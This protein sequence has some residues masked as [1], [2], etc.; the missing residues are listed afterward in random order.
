MIL[1]Q[2]DTVLNASVQQNSGKRNG[3]DVLEPRQHS[4]IE[5]EQKRNPSAKGGV[6]GWTEPAGAVSSLNG[7]LIDCTDNCCM[8][9]DRRGI[10][11]A[12]SQ[13]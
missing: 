5:E 11:A 13:V 6:G 4:V 2:Q 3:N 9:S 8:C 12:G 10:P 7:L 1:S